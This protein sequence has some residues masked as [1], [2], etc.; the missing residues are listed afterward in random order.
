MKI[1]KKESGGERKGKHTNKKSFKRK[2]KMEAK[3]KE[4]ATRKRTL[5]RLEEENE[6]KRQD[7]SF[8]QGY[9]KMLKK[10]CLILC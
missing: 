8:Y 6:V 2:Q 9:P 1:K 3:I 7:Y 4:D 5:E 10:I